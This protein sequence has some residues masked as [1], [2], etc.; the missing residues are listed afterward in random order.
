M[1][2]HN[3]QCLGPTGGSGAVGRWHTERSILEEKKE[4]ETNDRNDDDDDAPKGQQAEKP[5]PE[6]EIVE[7]HRNK[8]DNNIL[9]IPSPKA[10]RT[11]SASGS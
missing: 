2:V 6:I 1:L 10:C 5:M 3:Q 7:C 11:A 9:K 4:E 8:C